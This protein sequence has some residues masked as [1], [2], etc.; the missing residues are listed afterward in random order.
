MV[1]KTDDL[2][3]SFKLLTL[4]VPIRSFFLYYSSHMFTDHPE[5]VE[6]ATLII[7]QNLRHNQS[8]STIV[9]DRVNTFPS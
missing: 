5:K 2:S 4:K 8:I 6:R 9:R 7:E 1:P 3:Y